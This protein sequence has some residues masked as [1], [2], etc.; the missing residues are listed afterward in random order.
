[1]IKEF[2]LQNE[3]QMKQWDDF[4]AHH[5]EGTAFHL[6]GWIRTIHETYDVK[7]LLYVLQNGDGQLCGLAPFIMISSPILELVLYLFPFQITPV[8]SATT[9]P[10][11]RN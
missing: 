10:R 9:G 8:R 1:M 6:A 2:T 3:S 4:V 5:P 7:P 11:R